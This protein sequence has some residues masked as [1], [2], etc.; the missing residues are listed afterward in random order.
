MTATQTETMDTETVAVLGA[1][2]TDFTPAFRLT[3]AA[4]DAA[5]VCEAAEEH[6]LDLAG[7]RGHRAAAGGRRQ[8]AR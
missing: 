6:G 2:G 1:G 8:G 4:K 5:L 7:D 3:L